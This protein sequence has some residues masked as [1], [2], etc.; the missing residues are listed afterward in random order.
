MNIKLSLILSVAEYTSL[1]NICK[2]HELRVPTYTD[3]Y[4]RLRDVLI[5]EWTKVSDTCDINIM[6]NTIGSIERFQLVNYYFE[7]NFHEYQREV[8]GLSAVIMDGIK[9]IKTQSNIQ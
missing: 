2:A 4:I 6:R 9:V 1:N 7:Q 3:E 5:G 8:K